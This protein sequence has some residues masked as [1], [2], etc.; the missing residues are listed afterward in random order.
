[1]LREDKGLAQ[2]AH[3]EPKTSLLNSL[4]SKPSLAARPGCP[5]SPSDSLFQIPH[6]SETGK[7]AMAASLDEAVAGSYILGLLVE[8]AGMLA[9]AWV[10]DSVFSKVIASSCC[11]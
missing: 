2:I 5:A 7:E 11:K 6:L 4:N 3:T 8:S 10:Y 9:N 1:M